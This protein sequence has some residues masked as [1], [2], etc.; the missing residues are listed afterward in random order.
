MNIIDGIK[1]AFV[2]VCAKFKN[3]SP[4]KLSDIYSFFKNIPSNL[5]NVASSLFGRASKPVSPTGTTTKVIAVAEEREISPPQIIEINE[6]IEGDKNIYTLSLIVGGVEVGAAKLS[7]EGNS[8]PYESGFA[9]K[10]FI[11]SRVDVV[12]EH[13]N[14][15]YAHL[16]VEKAYETA[17]QK[18]KRLYVVDQAYSTHNVGSKLY[19]GEKI[20]QKF[21]VSV[22][23]NGQSNGDVYLIEKKT[24]LNNELSYLKMGEERLNVVILEATGSLHGMKQFHNY[25]KQHREQISF[26]KDLLKDFKFLCELAKK[27]QSHLS[28]SVREEYNTDYLALLSLAEN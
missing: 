8:D 20:R 27:S 28:T 13:R 25:I 17:L 7:E 1:I 26:L 12:K 23:I 19:G 5:Q 22:R 4:P 14:K 21:D 9:Q 11:L 3:L 16:L 10:T 6:S 2:D 15:G 24:R 18:G